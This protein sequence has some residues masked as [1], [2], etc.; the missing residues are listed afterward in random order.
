MNK[1]FIQIRRVFHQSRRWLSGDFEKD[2]LRA[3]QRK[4]HGFF[5]H[6]TPVTRLSATF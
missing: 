4:K 1:I 5:E 3:V 2:D 6:L